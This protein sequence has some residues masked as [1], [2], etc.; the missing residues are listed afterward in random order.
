MNRRGFLAA[1]IVA[2]FFPTAFVGETTV[3][4]KVV[5]V[6]GGLAGLSSAY[7]LRKAGF[8]VI[9]LEGQGRAGG[10]VQTLREGLYPELTAETGATRIPDKHYMTL[11]YVREFGLTLEPFHHGNLADVIHFRGQNYVDNHGPEP[12]WP[13]QLNPEERRLGRKGLAERYFADPLKLAAGS[14]RSLDVPKAILELD[15]F[16]IYEYLRSQGLSAEA[17][18]LTTLGFQTSVSAALLL[19]IE[20]NEQVS[21][22]YFHIRGGNDQLPAAF[23][24]RLGGAVRYGCRVTSIGQDDSSAWAVIEHAGEHEI[25]RGDYVVSALPFSIARDLFADA[26]LSLEKQRVIREL[27]YFPVN[28]VFLQMQKQ[29][30]KSNGQSGFANT[31]LLSQRFWSIGPEALDQRGL[32]LSYV[33]GDKAAKLDEMNIES[34][35]EATLADAERVFPGA[36]DNF[37]GSRSKSWSQDPWQRGGLTAFQ[38]GELSLIPVNARREGRIFFAG[39]HTSRWNGWMQ[40]AIESAQRVVNEISHQT[41]S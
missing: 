28:K 39:E 35:T 38:P 18:E 22:E 23:A 15:H 10:R 27:K 14:E 33:V 26:R 6:G 2:A 5:I 40:G 20:L 25:V 30:W 13:L 21:R 7:E 12:N 17:I 8:E 41:R 29:F 19:L 36:R 1:G 24:E 37:E 32:L 34:R 4:R 9:V 31:D 16:T 3:Q 11:S